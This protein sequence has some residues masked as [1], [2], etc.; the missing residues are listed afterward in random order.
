MSKSKI[1]SRAEVELS[2][3]QKTLEGKLRNDKSFKNSL[4]FRKLSEQINLKR[5]SITTLKNS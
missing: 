4:Q 1:I 5:T 2:E 3:L